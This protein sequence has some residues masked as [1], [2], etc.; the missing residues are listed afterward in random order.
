MYVTAG[1]VVANVPAVYNLSVAGKS[2]AL[3][4]SGATSPLESPGTTATLLPFALNSHNLS[5]SHVPP[6]VTNLYSY[7]P[8]AIPA[9]VVHV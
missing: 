8:G 4:F 5:V 7:C 6:F 3:P 2:V 9:C 1:V